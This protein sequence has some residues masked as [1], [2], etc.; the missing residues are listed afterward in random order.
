[1]E[2]LALGLLSQIPDWLTVDFILKVLDS[3]VFSAVYWGGAA[4]VVIIGFF[5]RMKYRD[6]NLKHLLN[7]YVAKATRGEGK[8]RLSVKDVIGRAMSKARG[9][10]AGGAAASTFNPADPFEDAARLWAQRQPDDAVVL[11]LRE[12][13]KCEAAV[14]Y[15]KHQLRLAQERA[16]TAYLEIAS[17]RRDQNRGLEALDAFNAML[18]VNPGDLDAL[19]MLG[20]QYRDLGRYREAEQNFTTLLFYVDK[21]LA[22]AADVK[23]ELGAVLV[24][25]KEYPRADSV[26]D[27]AMKIESDLSSQ[28]GVALCH[29]SIGTLRTAR[30]WWK[31]AKRSYDDSKAIFQTLGDAES[32]ERV[33]LL[34]ERMET[35]QKKQLRRR[36]EKRRVGKDAAQTSPDPPRLH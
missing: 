12:V 17:I 13:G 24:G 20:I 14:E 6:R 28:R 34:M 15:A 32:V 31:Q 3:K 21:D 22:A 35:A 25:S 11:L 18:R 16:A 4:I 2:A 7:G 10:P 5:A 26:L 36:Q 1:M 19:R 29:E 33:G 9:M 23:R 27:E 30:G 8:E